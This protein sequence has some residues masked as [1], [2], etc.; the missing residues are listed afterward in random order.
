M[1][2]SNFLHAAYAV[3]F[4]LAVG[5]APFLIWK[6]TLPLVIAGAGAAGF[7]V[8]VEWMQQIR[9]NLALEG[10]PWPTTL[11]IMDNVRGFRWTSIDRYGD[12]GIPA[13]AV[14]L[15]YLGARYGN[16]G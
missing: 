2:K 13:I 14:T 7:F 16:T 12:C 15:I 1:N 11:T 8:G 5:L 9:M 4:Q 10:R 3:G 6:T